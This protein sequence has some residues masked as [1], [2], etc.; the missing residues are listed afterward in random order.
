MTILG[1]I[2][3]CQG[4]GIIKEQMTV[5]VAVFAAVAFFK[6]GPTFVHIKA[7]MLITVIDE[8]DIL[9]C[10]YYVNLFH[11]YRLLGFSIIYSQVDNICLGIKKRGCR[12]KTAFF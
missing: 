2:Y 7:E 1:A 12:I 6:D 5:T 3:H 10:L 8:L 9:L 4:S 11:I